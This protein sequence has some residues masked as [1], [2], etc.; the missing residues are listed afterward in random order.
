MKKKKKSASRR[1]GGVLPIDTYSLMGDPD[2][3]A[4]IT[5]LAGQAGEVVR[6]ADVVVA[7]FEAVKG[8]APTP[9][10]WIHLK[11]CFRA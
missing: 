10:L 7:V 2:N 3:H 1:G 9:P 4:P 8:T 11:P 6:M 5:T